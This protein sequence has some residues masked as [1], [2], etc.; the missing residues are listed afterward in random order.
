MADYENVVKDVM[1]R[2]SGTNVEMIFGESRQIGDKVVIPV[3]KI[4]YRWGSGGGK[5]RGGPK[6]EAEGEG[7][8]FGLGMKVNVVPIGF[9]TV[10][11]DK[12]K[13]EPIVDIGPVMKIG[14][15]VLSL[16]ALK[17][18]KLMSKGMSRGYCGSRNYKQRR[19]QK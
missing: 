10:T 6:P 7:E 14:G 3:G 15:L 8:G 19:S 4:C 2:V 13:Y 9:I 12:V 1:A 16:A 5:G 11:A 17:L 18:F